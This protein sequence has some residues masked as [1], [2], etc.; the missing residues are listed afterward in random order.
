MVEG[1]RMYELQNT[2]ITLTRCN[3]IQKCIPQNGGEKNDGAN[4]HAK[5]ELH[6]RDSE[7]PKKIWFK[8]LRLNFEYFLKSIIFQKITDT[9]A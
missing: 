2:T 8:I 6:F 1:G 3:I 9:R 4:D 7:N 5:V